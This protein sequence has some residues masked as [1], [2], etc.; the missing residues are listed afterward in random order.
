MEKMGYGGEYLEVEKKLYNFT[1]PCSPKGESQIIK[2]R[3]I[4]GR[5]KNHL[6]ITLIL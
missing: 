5:F 1:P 6:G 2:F 4:P 3:L